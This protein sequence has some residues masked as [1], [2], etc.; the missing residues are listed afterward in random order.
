M[1]RKISVVLIYLALATAH[2]SAQ[3]IIPPGNVSGTWTA[4]GSPYL[5]MGEITVPTGQTLT[6][7]PEVEVIFQ[8]HYKFIINGYLEAI[9]TETDSILF[10]AADT[11]I[12]WHSLRFVNAPD[13]SHLAYCIVQYGKATGATIDD[14]IGGGI[15]CFTSNPVIS[16]CLIRW[17]YAYMFGGGTVSV[18]GGNPIFNYCTI[19]ENTAYQNAGVGGGWI[20]APHYNYCTIS[21]N[22]ATYVG[23]G[24]GGGYGADPTFDHCTISGNSAGSSAGVCYGAG[25]NPILTYCTVSGNSATDYR[26]GIGLGTDCGGL[27]DHCI[28]SGNTATW[29]GGIGV[30]LVCTTDITNCTICGNTADS[31]GGGIALVDN[32]SGTIDSCL[33]TGNSAGWNGGGIFCIGATDSATISHC[34]ISDNTA[35]NYGGGIACVDSANPTI[36]YC[37]LSSNEADSCGGGIAC[38]NSDPFVDHCTITGNDAAVYGGGTVSSYGSAPTYSYCDISANTALIHGGCGGGWENAS[39]TY[40]HCT[41]SNNSAIYAGGGMGHGENASPT[42]SYCT[43]SGNAAG[44]AG[45]G[46]VGFYYGCHGSMDNCTI[47][48]NSAPGALGGGISI[49]Y[50]A[51]P[52][53]S[54][55]TI[56]GNTSTGGIGGGII[57]AYV[58]NPTISNCTISGNSATNGGGIAADSANPTIENCTINDNEADSSSG[59]IWLIYSD[60]VIDSCTVSGNT[61]DFSYGGIGFKHS[62]PVI[63]NC[64]IEN[65]SALGSGIGYGGGG[66][67]YAYSSNSV[68][69]NC[70]FIGNMTYGV[71]GGLVVS[72]VGTS[73]TISHCTFTNDSAAWGGAILV[74]MGSMPTIERCTIQGNAAGAYGGGLHYAYGGG[75]ITRHCTISGN[76]SST[77]GSGIDVYGC[78]PTIKNTIVEGNTGGIAGVYSTN[79]IT[80]NYGDFWNNQ[81]AN[82]AGNVSPGIGQ[83]V[84][85][86]INGDSC[87]CY[88]NIFLDPLFVAPGNFHLQDDSPCIDAGD[89]ALPCDPDGTIADIGRYY[90]DQ[91]IPNL[92]I[93][94]TPVNPPIVIPAS[95][96]S[97]TFD[98]TMTNN[99][100]I[101]ENFD[102]WIMVRLPNQSWYGPVLGPI[103]LTLPAGGTLTRQ[104]IQ[105]VPGNAPAGSYWYE[106]RVGDHPTVI[107]DTSGFAFTK[108][109]ADDGIP[110]DDWSCTGQ[111]FEQEATIT[112]STPQSFTLKGACP[113]P[114]NPYTNI[115]FALPEDS[116]V[117]LAIFDVTGRQVASLVEGWREAGTHVVT[118]DGSNLASGVYIYCMRAG[119]FIASEK[120]VLVK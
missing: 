97:F 9:G 76:H 91:P 72:Q 79:A 116:R 90:F 24:V 26:G 43:I 118:F 113:N 81:N 60:A 65:N 75:G 16:H 108:T 48:G 69:N 101:S 114:F 107:W 96:G 12:G 31:S 93:T 5:I 74:G 28:I 44:M 103:N 32:Y 112:A 64:L 34:A 68:I 33:I 17:N 52:I 82:F 119:A 4:T 1:F 85:V 109:V 2:V 47:T 27:M 61:A 57:V 53:I 55:C 50:V 104:R 42:I 3:T 63:T 117:H 70:N 41:I 46:G 78:F 38:R 6:I 11:A 35:G 98:A 62:S 115:S 39:P 71:G 30:G 23:G 100:A 105:N 59:G 86:N 25:A 13:S 77:G 84:S 36:E 51:D 66:L 18:Y 120:M 14:M 102:V 20:T 40:L 8:G 106:A 99:E 92:T 10:T 87:D 67:G 88:H 21:G 37:T 58:A 19:S 95:G 56:T 89:P 94:L 83:Q 110:V 111:S 80:I 7:Q 49:A 15:A 54:N 45:T 22:T 29:H 73:G